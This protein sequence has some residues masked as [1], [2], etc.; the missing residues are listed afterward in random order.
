MV[1]NRHPDE[2]PSIDNDEFGISS[3]YGLGNIRSVQ[4]YP[5]PMNPKEKMSIAERRGIWNGQNQYWYQ[6]DP[7]LVIDYVQDSDLPDFLKN[8]KAK[9]QAQDEITVQGY[10]EIGGAVVCGRRENG[11][12]TLYRLSCWQR[13]LTVPINVFNPDEKLT[14]DMNLSNIPELKALKNI[15]PDLL[16]H[17]TGLTENRLFVRMKNYKI[18]L[19]K[20]NDTKALRDWYLLAPFYDPVTNSYRETLDKSDFIANSN[21]E[22][23]PAISEFNPQKYVK[24]LVP[25]TLPSSYW[26][27]VHE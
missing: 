15:R 21:D 9:R 3:S 27:S 16:E 20:P 19:D 11:L 22:F 10:Y 6:L 26:D 8:L 24:K 12:L 23:D 14:W 7:P 2:K 17:N 18:K 1:S 25:Y 4:I 5:P 13:T